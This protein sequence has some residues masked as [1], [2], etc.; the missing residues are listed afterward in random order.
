MAD[1]D[2]MIKGLG[3]PIEGVPTKENPKAVPLAMFLDLMEDFLAL[4]GL[5]A[6]LTA[7]EEE[8]D[9]DPD[10][11]DWEAQDEALLQADRAARQWIIQGLSFERKM[12]CTGC[13]SCFCVLLRGWLGNRGAG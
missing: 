10:N 2:D 4:K 13:T 5:D 7:D 3:A 12:V 8:D 9:G 1:V 6:A 11:F